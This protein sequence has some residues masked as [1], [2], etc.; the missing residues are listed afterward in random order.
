M[1]QIIY[2]TEDMRMYC[3]KVYEMVAEELF[4]DDIPQNVCW[5]HYVC[6]SYIKVVSEN[7][8]TKGYPVEKITDYD[9][10][11]RAKMDELNF[12][13]IPAGYDTAETDGGTY[14]FRSIR[15]GTDEEKEAFNI[16]AIKNLALWSFDIPKYTKK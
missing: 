6:S 8:K 7:L 14:L 1:Q 2:I 10:N 15:T 3:E 5:I 9:F 11:F 12:V 13:Y 4:T 16:L